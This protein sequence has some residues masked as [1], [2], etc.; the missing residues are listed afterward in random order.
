VIPVGRVKF[1]PDSPHSGMDN[2]AWV[3][4]THPS[5]EPTIFVFRDPARAFRK[6]LLWRQAS[7]RRG[8]ATTRV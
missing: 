3:K 1:I 8:S 4:F 2:V 5:D 6:A 7:T